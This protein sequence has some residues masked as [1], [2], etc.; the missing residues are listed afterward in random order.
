[1]K[2]IIALLLVVC[3]FAV[4][5]TGCG[6]PAGNTGGNSTQ[7]ESAAEDSGDEV[8]SD[9]GSETKEDEAE[10][11]K[12]DAVKTANIGVIAWSM[13][14]APDEA[15]FVQAVQTTLSEQYSDQI[16]DVFVMDAQKDAD[17]LPAIM[18]NIIAM[19]EG[20]NVAVL[21]VNDENGFS[22]EELLGV[23]E[24]AEKA[25]VIT[26]VDHV[27]DGAPESTFVYDAS[28]AAGCAS[29]IVENAFK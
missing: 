14:M 4:C 5:F 15:E 23:L 8:I 24:D 22:D 10:D 17:M 7:A 26:G 3:V 1:M 21:I 28:D 29:M 19:W 18:G 13:G 12:N 25:G 6:S 9:A 27:I 20:E 16:D 11:Y 2:K